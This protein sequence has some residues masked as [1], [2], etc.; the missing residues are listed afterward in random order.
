MKIKNTCKRYITVAIIIVMIVAFSAN[1]LAA[2]NGTTSTSPPQSFEISAQPVKGYAQINTMNNS[3]KVSFSVYIP[4]KNMGLLQYYVNTISTPG[5]INYHHFLSLSQ[6]YKEFINVTGYKD[7]ISYLKSKGFTIQFTAMDS[8][9]VATGTVFQIHNYLGLSIGIY[10]NG[11]DQYYSA[12]GTPRISGV[13]I[14]SSNITDILFAHPTYF[15]NQSMINSLYDKIDGS[16]QQVPPIAATNY[17]ATDLQT[18]YNATGLYKEGINGKGSNIGILDYSGDPYLK[19]QLSYFDAL[20]NVPNPPNFSVVPIGPYN[21]ALGVLDGWADEISMDVEAAHTMAPGANITLY[22]ANQNILLPVAIAYIDQ[23]DI[24]NDLS[25]SFGIPESIISDYPAATVYFNFI[26][27]DIYYKLGSVEGITFI[28]SSGDGGGSGYSTGPI[29]TIGYPASSPYVTAVGGTTTYLTFKGNMVYSFNQTAWSNHGFVPDFLNF[30]GSTGGVSVL[31]PRP[32]Y[33]NIQDPAT[34]PNGRMVPDISLE[35]SGSPGIWY[36]MPGNVLN[37]GG[38]TSEASPLLAGLL[39]LVSQYTGSKTGLINPALYSLGTNAS[40]YPKVFYPITYGYNIPWAS[41]YGYNL[42]TGF[43]SINIGAFATIYS[44]L[45]ASKT[46]KLN[47]TVSLLNS[48][49]K[50]AFEFPDN[51]NIIVLA[52]ITSQAGTEIVTGSFTATLSSLQGNISQIPLKYNSSVNEWTGN[53]TVPSNSEGLANV[54][55][56]GTSLGVLGFESTEIFLGYYLFYYEE[57]TN[58]PFLLTSAVGGMY[59]MGYVSWL[60]GSAVTNNL[61]L[62]IEHYSIISN[63]YTIVGSSEMTNTGIYIRSLGDSIFTTILGNYSIGEMVLVAEGAYSYFPFFNGADLQGS[64]ILGSTFTEPG[65]AAAGQNITL[66]PQ[67]TPPYNIYNPATFANTYG[68]NITF[69]LLSPTGKVVSRSAP[70]LFSSL[71]VLKVPGNVSSGLYTVLIN[72]SYDSYSL[73]SWINGSYYGQIYISNSTTTAT[74]N[75]NSPN[76]EEGMNITVE[77]NIRYTNGTEVKYGMYSAILYPSDLASSY[78]LLTEERY[79]DNSLIPLYYNASLNLWTANV[80]LPSGT[81]AGSMANLLNDLPDWAG[82]YTASIVGLSANGYPTVVSNPP[83][84][85]FYIQ[86]PIIANLNNEVNQLHYQLS[87]NLSLINS[88]I[89]MEESNVSIL[90][91]KV[92][93]LNLTVTSLNLSMIRT[94]INTLETSIATMQNTLNSLSAQLNSINAS[95]EGQITLLNSEINYLKSTYSAQYTSLNNSVNQSIMNL[96][97]Q[98]SNDNSFLKSNVTSLDKEISSLQVTINNLNNTLVHESSDIGKT[99]N[100]VNSN[101][102]M[103]IL[104]LLI[105]LISLALVILVYFKIPKKP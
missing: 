80:T 96:Q 98:I 9:I 18:V 66:M 78:A 59:I 103:G 33:Q 8:I 5:S 26:L 52:N 84:V 48:A 37:T 21:P 92:N 34:Y 50:P 76:L 67:F 42:V 54:I 40:T 62:S 81:N 39:A 29:G 101:Y 93:T 15:L 35:S 88:K 95:I 55:V 74:V 61:T 53:I 69:S 63:T 100:N 25:Q 7:T 68:S 65:T 46:V 17:V 64:Y 16:T 79:L 105:A 75:I 47:V 71:G 22:I 20:Y 58:S 45:K 51:Q 60:N 104:A 4:I 77:A 85:S 30:G 102:I 72:S 24:V 73:G 28:A 3:S 31:E 90:T 86:N 14:Y 44:S 43:G 10:S 36:V 56:K 1:L 99:N 70:V 32:W 12:Y 23:Q 83:S 49:K 27:P 57:V 87:E 19:E 2:T 11:K 94:T 6:I 89:A 91:E 41:H 38:G 97:N 13:Y 82:N